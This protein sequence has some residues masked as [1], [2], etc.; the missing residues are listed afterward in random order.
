MTY[1]EWLKDYWEN[2]SKT[3][4][5]GQAFWNDFIVTP[6]PDLYYCTELAKASHLLEMWLHD[7][8]YYTTLPEKING[9]K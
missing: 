1:R 7:H 3:E 2:R 4:R 6:W 8:H 9:T 5:L